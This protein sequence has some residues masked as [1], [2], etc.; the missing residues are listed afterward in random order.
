M[1]WNY[2]M[3]RFLL[4]L[5]G[6]IPLCLQ[7]GC[8]SS[9][10]LN[11]QAFVSMVILDKAEQGV[12]LTL[13]FP[14]TNRLIPGSAGGSGGSGGQKP[15][16]FLSEVGVDIGQAYR[17]IQADLSRKITF[18]QTYIVIFGEALAKEGVASALDFL[19]REPA[20]HINANLFVT[21]G[22]GKQLI[23][24]PPIFERFV[25]DILMA[26]VEEKIALSATATDFL[27]A[28][29]SGGDI[30]IPLLSFEKRH[31]DQEQAE[32]QTWMGTG[33]AAI[34]KQGR[35]VGSLT[36]QEMRGGLWVLEQVK[37]SEIS[38]P[39]R[40][41]GK[42]IDVIIRQLDTRIRPKINN[43][44]ITITIR[45]KAIAEIIAS[46]SKIDLKDPDHLRELEQDLNKRVKNVMMQTID[47]TREVKSDVFHFGDY[48]DWRYPREWKRIKTQ[49]HDLYSKEIAI[50]VMIDISISRVGTIQQ[51]IHAKTPEMAVDS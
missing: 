33:G 19:A 28:S 21:S 5:L 35:M 44:K 48:L 38:I 29:Y 42:N 2:R 32:N 6:V 24:V 1:K 34:F 11:E 27:K 22:E 37:D 20:F 49:W 4:F 12:E 30:I 36:T 51:P 50:E 39:S 45:S 13:A 16:T 17:R 23:K 43:E 10:E 40:T 3:K 9:A 26:F 18:G 31:I 25:S 8:W 47:K 15:Y 41:D 7:A 46:N 14:L